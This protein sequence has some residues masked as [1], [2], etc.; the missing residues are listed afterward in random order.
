MTTMRVWQANHA[1]GTPRKVWAAAIIGGELITRWAAAGNKLCK[2]ASIDLK[3]ATPSAKLAEMERD[4]QRKRYKDL[5]WKEVT[6][7]GDILDTPTAQP[8]KPQPKGFYTL[9]VN[10][11]A[12]LTTTALEAAGFG[13]STIQSSTTIT[14]AGLPVPL[15]IAK[16]GDW[17]SAAVPGDKMT[18]AL[19]V[20]MLYLAKSASNQKMGGTVT[21]PKGELIAHEFD[22]VLTEFGTDAKGFREVAESLGLA[23]KAFSSLLK[24]KSGLFS[25]LNLQPTF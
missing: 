24:K 14:W 19:L 7:D 8:A 21:N 6:D 20:A 2:P 23:P 1:D 16:S 22:A 9:R 25:A 4:K 12:T 11:G 3:G 10:A 17:L 18:A 13:V 5:G 15:R